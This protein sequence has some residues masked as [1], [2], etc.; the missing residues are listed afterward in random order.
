MRTR[1][2]PLISEDLC[3]GCEICQNKCPYKA[4][5][6]INLSFE[7]DEPIHS[8]G[9]NQFRLHGLPI[10]KEKAV[11]GFVG[12]NGIGKTTI[13]KILSGN[14]IPNFNEKESSKQKVM[15]FYKGKEAFDYFKKVY[16][17][18]IKVAVKPQ[19]I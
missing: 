19:N 1:I 12:R 17:Q 18:G 8:F 15:D 3:I 10:P 5:S 13:V 6:I 11:L 14:I 7:L 16:G 4:I 9:K 2:K